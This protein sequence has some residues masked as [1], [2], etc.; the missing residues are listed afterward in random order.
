[1]NPMMSLCKL[2]A[3]KKHEILITFVVTEEWFGLISPHCTTNNI[4]FSTIPNILPSEH[5]RGADFPGFYEA[6]MTKMEAPFDHLLVH[7]DL[8]VD[9][10]ITDTELPWAIRVAN[11]RNIP[12]A[13]FSTLSAT[14][15]SIL[16]HFYYIR[17][18]L[19]FRNL[20]GTSLNSLWIVH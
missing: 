3:S 8:P 10:V 15:F 20:L 7:L 12:V 9:A 19:M 16:R 5:V 17:D 6:V 4:R 14:V 2:L 18:H 1:M 13:A 11:E